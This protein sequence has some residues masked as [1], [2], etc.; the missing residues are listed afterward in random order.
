VPLSQPAFIE[1]IAD[2]EARYDAASPR[3]LAKEATR[4]SAE[5]RELIDAAP[6]FALATVGSDGMDCSPRGDTAPSVSVIDDTTL[7]IPDRKGN[8]RLDSLRNIV[9]DGRV[10]LL[11]LIPGL[12]ICMR[13]NGRAQLTVDGEV[14]AH[15]AVDGILPRSVIV[16][17]IERVY[18][19]CARAIR[20]AA[21]WDASAQRSGADLP[22]AGEILAAVN[23]PGVQS[24]AAYNQDFEDNATLY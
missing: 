16:V 24:A 8:N 7:H 5:Y 19:Q 6:F 4:L 14:L 12:D 21:L 11:F 22:T 23:A 18:F 1:T 15:H 13:I 10:A 20:R 2:L 9:E 3:S 17:S